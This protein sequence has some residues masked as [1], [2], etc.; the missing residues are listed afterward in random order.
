MFYGFNHKWKTGSFRFLWSY[1][2]A[3]T[4]LPVSINE[5]KKFLASTYFWIRN[6]QRLF[7][8]IKRQCWYQNTVFDLEIEICNSI[9]IECRFLNYKKISLESVTIEFLNTEQYFSKKLALKKRMRDHNFTFR[10]QKRRISG[11][12]I[13]FQ[14]GVL[15][16]S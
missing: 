1:I 14:F 16:C 8:N 11:F 6:T 12:V 7:R 10:M 3:I 9:F 15:K 2:N 4:Q 5:K 13:Q